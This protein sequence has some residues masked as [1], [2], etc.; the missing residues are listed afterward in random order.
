MAGCADARSGPAQP[1]SRDFQ[2]FWFGQTISLIG[3]QITTFALPLT[4][5]LVLG[6]SARE[7]G[8]L[9]AARTLPF[10]LVTLPA[11]LI[12]D[13]FRRRPLLIGADLG[14]AGLLVLV[15][16]AALQGLLKIEFLYAIAFAAGVLTVLFE[17]AY[18]TVAPWLVS[19]PQLVRA[20]SRLM[21]SQ[22]FGEVVGPALG[23][24]L[25][26]LLTAPIAILVDGVSFLIGALALL[27]LRTPEPNPAP[28]SSAPLLAQLRDGFRIVAREPHVRAIGLM[29]A[30]Y[31][32]IETA[33]ITLLL[34]FA[35]A[36]GFSPAL[37]GLVLGAGAL[38]AFSGAF[39]A[40]P[41]GRRFGIGPTTIIAMLIETGVFIP[42]AL[43]R[44]ASVAS[45][46]I[47]ALA[48]FANGWGTCVSTVQS[49]SVRQHVTPPHLLGRMNATYRLLVTGTVPI[50]ALLASWLGETL[51]ISNALLLFA[52]ALP[53]SLLPVLF[54]PLR[55]LRALS[56][57]RT[58]TA[59]RGRD[60]RI[61]P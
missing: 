51:G 5:I 56:E 28:R 26:Q 47:F 24:Q 21:A 3:S 54:S 61:P 22:S 10:L 20:N 34:L 11:G 36:I 58:R 39:V 43:L 16:L 37:L 33:V 41:L 4:A 46:G 9:Q 59:S 49:M 23:G 6:A 38:G 32:M 53:A 13:R 45:A 14:R 2:T 50:G 17:V 19:S 7:M 15:P 52:I 40:E 44:D 27:M 8:L 18:I 31:N 57:T 25:V 29:A 42:V 30:S 60:P 12:V 1:L 35:L 55:T 48:L